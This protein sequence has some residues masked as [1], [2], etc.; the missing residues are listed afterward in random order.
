MIAFDLRFA[1]NS[2][3]NSFVLTE[4]GKRLAECIEC[5]GEGSPNSPLLASSTP[6]LTGSSVMVGLHGGRV[7]L[8]PGDKSI[9]LSV[10]NRRP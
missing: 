10:P 7:R 8:L 3:V 9:V 2:R 1:E 5:E 6:A 4:Y